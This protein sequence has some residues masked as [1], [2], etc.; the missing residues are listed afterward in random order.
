LPR[1]TGRIRLESPQHTHNKAPTTLFGSL[2]PRRRLRAGRRL[3]ARHLRQRP[4]ERHPRHRCRRLGSTCILADFYYYNSSVIVLFISIYRLPN[5]F[6]FF[7]FCSFFVA[8]MWITFLKKPRCFLSFISY[9]PP[10]LIIFEQDI[11]KEDREDGTV[12]WRLL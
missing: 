3:P 4:L 5:H 9:L 1:T 7:R 6:V 11:W 2:R 8:F 12:F 10:F